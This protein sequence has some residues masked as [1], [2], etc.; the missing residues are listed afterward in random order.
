[1]PHRHSAAARPAPVVHILDGDRPLLKALERQ[2]V[3]DGFRVSVFTGVEGFL[4]CATLDGPGCLIVDPASIE[5]SCFGRHRLPVI[6]LTA[7][8]DVE[9]SVDAMKRGAID[10]LLKPVR[11]EALID[12][13]NRALDQDG[14]E[15]T[16]RHAVAEVQELHERLTPRE[17]EVFALVVRGLLNKQ[18]AAE[19]GTTERTVKAHR[20][21]VMR[22]MRANSVAD[23][24]RLAGRLQS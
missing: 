4:S 15:R 1:M 23:L 2:F 14:R 8:A 20:S 5:G 17:S 7:R 24:T 3:A 11:R 13:V 10:F 21:R 18:I 6:I 22:K 12:A 19:L 9:M 16:A